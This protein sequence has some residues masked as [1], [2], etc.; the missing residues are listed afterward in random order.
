MR[1]YVLMFV[2]ILFVGTSGMVADAVIS[3]V[4][5]GSENLDGYSG[6]FYSTIYSEESESNISQRKVTSGPVSDGRGWWRRGKRQN[7]GISEYV[8]YVSRGHASVENGKGDYHSGG[9]KNAYIWSKAKLDWTRS[10]NK[11][12]YN[13]R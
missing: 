2:L 6:V 4:G 9:W 7:E 11:A 13:Y 5:G 12:Y 3:S 8:D 1:K 10:G